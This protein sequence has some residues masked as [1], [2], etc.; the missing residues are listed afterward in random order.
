MINTLIKSKHPPILYSFKINLQLKI[1]FSQTRFFKNVRNHPPRPTLVK[2]HL[3]LINKKRK[4]S[5]NLNPLTMKFPWKR[6]RKSRKRTRKLIWSKNKVE[7]VTLI[8]SENSSNFYLQNRNLLKL[9]KKLSKDT[10]LKSMLIAI[11]GRWREETLTTETT[12][13]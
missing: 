10:I 6:K 8:S 9:F 1:I 4:N 5:W 13:E 3:F 12:L 11:L 2:L 7:I